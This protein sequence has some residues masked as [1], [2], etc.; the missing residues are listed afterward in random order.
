MEN[1]NVTGLGL[2]KGIH[3]PHYGVGTRGMP[4]RRDFRD[5]IRKTGAMGIAIENNC[6]LAFVD[7]RFYRVIRSK[8]NARAYRVYKKGREIN[9]R[10]DHPERRTFSSR[11][12]LPSIPVCIS[13]EGEVS[14]GGSAT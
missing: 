8:S 4:R 14:F 2:I 5:L 7:G 10:T 9:R 6:G 1:I 3:C 12:P 13:V 11:R